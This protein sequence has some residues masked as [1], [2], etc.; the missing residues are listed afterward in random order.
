MELPKSQSDGGSQGFQ[1]IVP[2]QQ[3]SNWLR[4]IIFMEVGHGREGGRLVPEEQQRDPVQ[5]TAMGQAPCAVPKGGEIPPAS[6]YV[7]MIMYSAV[8]LLGA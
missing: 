1:L 5:L 2:S 3:K 6:Q 7:N 8:V 4:A